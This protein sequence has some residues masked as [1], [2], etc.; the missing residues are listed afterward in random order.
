[1]NWFPSYSIAPSV[2]NC[3][4]TY[5]FENVNYLFAGN[6]YPNNDGN[7]IYLSTN[8]GENWISISDNLPNLP[9]SIVWSLASN[10]E[11]IFAAVNSI[12][13]RRPFEEILEI[14]KVLSEEP[15]IA[16]MSHKTIQTHLTQALA[17]SMQ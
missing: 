16:F 15:Q 12:V 2:P 9:S 10:S 8:E 13:W 3:L 14:T 6:Y 1:M 4:L 5:N 11:Y 17:F 7:I